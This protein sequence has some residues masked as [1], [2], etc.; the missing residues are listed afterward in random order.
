M[1]DGLLKSA[2]RFTE[3]TIY[4]V[5]PPPTGRPLIPTMS[6]LLRVGRAD[7]KH[8]LAFDRRSC[9][10][11]SYLQTRLWHVQSLEGCCLWN[12]VRGVEKSRT[13]SR[14]LTELSHDEDNRKV[15]INCYAFWMGGAAEGFV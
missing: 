8:H 11:T 9:G 14:K 10:R 7:S 4:C 12:S 13:D 2:G 6:R 3:A 1:K 5:A 15:S